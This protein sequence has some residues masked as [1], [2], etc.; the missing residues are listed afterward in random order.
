M[1]LTYEAMIRNPRIRIVE[2]RGKGI[3]ISIFETLIHEDGIGYDF[4]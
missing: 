3:P 2:H 4:L 1:N